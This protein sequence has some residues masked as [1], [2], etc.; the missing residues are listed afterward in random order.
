MTVPNMIRRWR[1]KTKMCI[2]ETIKRHVIG[3]Y[4]KIFKALGVNDETN[5]ES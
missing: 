5:E 2:I 4:M 1:Q 3:H